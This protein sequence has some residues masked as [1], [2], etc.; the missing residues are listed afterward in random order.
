MNWLRI[1]KQKLIYKGLVQDVYLKKAS[2]LEIVFAWLV[3]LSP[4]I[5]L[6]ILIKN[7]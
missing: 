4:F 6:L 2:P 5:V 3:V 1:R 7:I